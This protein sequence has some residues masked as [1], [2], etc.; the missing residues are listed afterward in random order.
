VRK[1]TNLILYAEPSLSSSLL[2]LVESCRF[3]AV[4]SASGIETRLVALISRPS[5]VS[6]RLLAVSSQ[7]LKGRF[8]LSF[9]TGQWVVAQCPRS[10]VALWKV[11]DMEHHA[12]EIQ[13]G[14]AVRFGIRY[15]HWMM[16]AGK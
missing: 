6:R 13:F 5:S 12:G 4:I 2:F 1:A 3:P 16:M 15:K 7:A 14:M 9:D 11:G 8:H 10:L